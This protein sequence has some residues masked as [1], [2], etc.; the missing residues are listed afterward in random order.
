[1]SDIQTKSNASQL[2]VDSEIGGQANP[3]N[4]F[5]LH[6]EHFE[7]QYLFND[8]ADHFTK[9]HLQNLL[10]GDSEIGGQANPRQV[11]LEI[12][13]ELKC[14]KLLDDNLHSTRQSDEVFAYEWEIGGNQASPRPFFGVKDGNFNDIGGGQI[15]PRNP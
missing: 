5:A 9:Q 6:P 4:V 10:Q 3:R 13:T 15:A 1:M 7:C 8:D 14:I 11:F 12:D 2:C